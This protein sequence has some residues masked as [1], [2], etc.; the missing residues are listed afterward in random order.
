MVPDCNPDLHSR[1]SV[2]PVLVKSVVPWV[3]IVLVLTV[4]CIAIGSL[5]FC[6]PLYKYWTVTSAEIM[7]KVALIPGVNV[8]TVH[9]RRVETPDQGG[10]RYGDEYVC[11]EIEGHLFLVHHMVAPATF[12]LGCLFV[13]AYI[14]VLFTEQW[15]LTS[16]CKWVDPFVMGEGICFNYP[17]P[18][19]VDCNAWNEAGKE[20]ALLC[21]SLSINV[22]GVLIKFVALVGFQALI[23]R[24]LS[25]FIHRGCPDDCFGE[26]M[27]K[28]YLTI[29]VFYLAFVVILLVGL[30]VLI[31]VVHNSNN[32][33]GILVNFILP[34]ANMLMVGVL[35]LFALGIFV[36]M[37][38]RADELTPTNE[39]TSLIT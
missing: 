16:D 30:V 18:Y 38:R 29:L 8:T 11:F 3:V 35:E 27:W 12:A 21:W 32:L 7:V 2:L 22:F 13:F 36:C 6:K 9:K 23:M 28:Q 37:L 14:G 17:C 5:A 25:L 19:S 4:V 24:F 33:A 26:D 15:K 39:L 20:E 34:F 10:P 31:A 1:E